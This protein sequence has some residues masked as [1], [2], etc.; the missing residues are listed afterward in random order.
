MI[1][2]HALYVAVRAAAG[3]LAVVLLARFWNGGPGIPANNFYLIAALLMCLGL[4]LLTDPLIDD[5]G[6]RTI[7]KLCGYT[8]LCGIAIATFF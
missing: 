3:L 1:D 7:A 8:G 5:A 6:L 4:V 2:R